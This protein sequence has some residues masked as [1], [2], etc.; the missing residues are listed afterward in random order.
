MISTL[1]FSPPRFNLRCLSVWLRNVSVWKKLIGPSLLI[2]FGEPF[3]YLLGLGYGLGQFVGDING[4]PYL[5]F[6]ASG[7]VAFSATN[8][9]SF[10]ALYSVFT[11]MVPQRTYEAMLATPLTVDDI[12]AGEMLW[13]AT[14]SLISG[15][16]IL[17]VAAFLGAVSSTGAILVIPVLF[18]TG[19]CFS[20]LALMMTAVSR[21]YDFF[22]Y[23]MTL[24]ITPM[25]LFCGVFYPIE[26]LPNFLEPIARAL[27]LAHTIELTRPLIAGGTIDNPLWHL[28]ALS[29]FA[30]VGYYIAVVLIRRRLIV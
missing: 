11:R 27:P 10:E 23:Y 16:A 2:N 7:M 22:N 25:F 15:T 5:V 14:K 28:L 3:L 29:L 17:V 4:V 26:T 30:L 9:A 1:D 19:L 24:F 21:S 8:T 18:L 13:C 6:L 20:G 12:V